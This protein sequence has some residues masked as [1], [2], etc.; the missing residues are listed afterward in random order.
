MRAP[1]II[2]GPGIPSG[3]QVDGFAYLLDI[4]PTLGELAQI[5]AP[6]GSEGLSLVP[7]LDGR[8]PSVRNSIFTAYAQVQR[9]VRDDRWK[10]IVYPKI[11]KTQLFDLRNDPNE[12]QDLV[13]DPTGAGQVERLTRL[14]RD[15]QGEL[16]DALPL[17]SPKPLPAQ[18]R[19]P[20]PRSAKSAP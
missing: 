18:F 13:N 12:T 3:R 11:N 4:F 16:G 15:W 1:L 7:I 20:S 17:S 10:M 2:A 14:L 9:A 6:E 8:R 5:P 19:F